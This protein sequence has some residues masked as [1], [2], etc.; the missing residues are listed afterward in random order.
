[1]L[2]MLHSVRKALNCQSR[3]SYSFSMIM[4]CWTLEPE[5]RPTFKELSSDIDE[6][7]QTAAGYL[8]LN[9]VLL[10]PKDEENSIDS[11]SD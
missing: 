1:M 6:L 8:E 4:K 11:D 2:C 5:D 3:D 7:L 10:P 9:M